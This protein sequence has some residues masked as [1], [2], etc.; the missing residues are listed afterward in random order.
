ME[1]IVRDK[2]VVATDVVRL[3]LSAPDGAPLPPFKPGAHVEVRVGHLERRYSLTSSPLATDHYEICVLKATPGRGGSRYIHETLAIGDRLEV[4]GPV[5]GF[6]LQES[7]AHTVFIAGGIGI[8]PFLSMMEALDR[9]ERTF[10]LHYTARAADRFLPIPSHVAHVTRYHG[11]ELNIDGLLARVAK[12]CHLY[13]CGPTGMVREATER[14]HASGWPLSAIH[15]ESFGSFVSIHDTQIEVELVRSGITVSVQPGT[16]I[17][18]ALHAAGVWVPHECR[19][20]Q[21]G[22]CVT[23]ILAGTA[24]HRD[25]CLT[26]QQRE[27]LFCTCVSWATAPGLALEI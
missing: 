6:P 22:A 2:A 23:P 20:G 15:S 18:D 8:T 11:R 7:A 25:I 5:N 26:P 27:T 24:D 17:L 10:E 1:L 3:R 12:P 19:R 21:C 13:V 16:T 9:A 14:A 4:S